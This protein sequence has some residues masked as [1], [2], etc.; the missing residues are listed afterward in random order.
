MKSRAQFKG[1]P[2]HPA[3]VAF[4]IAFLC[5][6]AVADV[7]ALFFGWRR[8]GVVGSCLSV[9][10]VGTGLAAGVPGLIDYLTVVPPGSSGKRRATK[11]MAV[12]LTA[13]ALV[14]IG[15]AFRD[16]RS[17]TPGWPAVVLELGAVALMTWGGWMGGTLVYRNQIGVDHRY[18]RAGKWHEARVDGPQGGTVVLDGAER[19]ETG[20]MWLVRWGNRRIVLART[21]DGFAAFDDAC[22]HRGGSLADGALVCGTVQCPWHGSQFDVAD[23]SVRAGPADRP[24][25]TCRAELRDGRVRLTLPGEQEQRSG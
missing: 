10:A 16:W 8:F 21:A 18:A 17:L 5:G 23:G 20:Q 2:L 24:I 3:L 15:W 13:L 14:A 9:A 25:G 19:L 12:N 1:H 6:C 4:P 11:H 7:L 22:T